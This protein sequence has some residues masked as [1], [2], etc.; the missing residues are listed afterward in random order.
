MKAESKN[1]QHRYR[2]SV[3]PPSCSSLQS[4]TSKQTPHGYAWKL[5]YF[6]IKETPINQKTS[7]LTIQNL[8]LIYQVDT[9]KEEGQWKLCWK[10][11]TWDHN[12]G[13]KDTWGCGRLYFLYWSKHSNTDKELNQNKLVCKDQNN[14]KICEFLV[15]WVALLALSVSHHGPKKCQH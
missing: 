14:F 9:L 6:I 8:S 4:W 12:T 15:L 13:N 10:I 3:H 5:G 2:T 7:F 11:E 1:L